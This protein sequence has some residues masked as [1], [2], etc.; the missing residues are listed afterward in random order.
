MATPS[1]PPRPVRVQ[2][3]QTIVKQDIPNIPPRPVRKTDPSPDRERFTRSPLNALPGF[4]PPPQPLA[5]AVGAPRRPS[6]INL[7][8]D[9]GQ[10]GS[11]Y[12][13]Y[14]QLPDEAHGVNID[15]E[16]HNVTANVPLHAPKASVPASLAKRNIAKVTKTDSLGVAAKNRSEEDVLKYQPETH[17]P[18]ARVTSRDESGQR[19]PPST[20]P[21]PL[22][23][24]T[25]FSRSHQSLPGTSRPPSMHGDYDGIPEIGRQIP[26]YPNAGDVQAPSPG[27]GQS[28]HAPGIGF[29]NDGSARAHHRKRSSRHEFGPP[30]TYGLHGHGVGPQDQFER[31]WA[32]K[33]PDEAA[34][35]STAHHLPRP[36]SAMSTEQ[37]NRLVHLMQEDAGM[38]KPKYI[39]LVGSYDVLTTYA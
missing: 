17:S 37:L 25:S 4:R 34:R 11:E 24:R 32:A 28:Q 14:D 21:H 16:T 18:L 35:E 8:S 20:E 26:L 10:E 22:R 19:R 39:A 15:T 23:N 33:H 30:D 6:S 38:G 12:S 27:P 1:V 7:P 13:S 9:A 29:F 3:G 2:G 31:N 5:A 36:A